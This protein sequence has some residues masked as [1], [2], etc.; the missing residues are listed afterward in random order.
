[1]ARLQKTSSNLRRLQACLFLGLVAGSARAQ[2]PTTTQPAA[3]SQNAQFV[4]GVAPGY[5][6]QTGPGLI[7]NL[8][9]GTAWCGGNVQ[10]YGGGALTLT[11][12][13]TNYVY[14]DSQNLCVPS[15]K[16][17]ALNP[18]DIPLAIVATSDT[19]ILGLSDVRT[20]FQPQGSGSPASATYIADFP[21]VVATDRLNNCLTAASA[22]TLVCD[23][24]AL[25]GTLTGTAFTIPAKTWLKTGLV[26]L[27]LSPGAGNF[28]IVMADT[29]RWSGFSSGFSSLHPGTVV[30]IQNSG[31]HG[32]RFN[33]TNTNPCTTGGVTQSPVIEGVEIRNANGTNTGIGIDWS[34]VQ[35]GTFFNMW[36]HQWGIA[37]LCNSTTFTASEN[38][39]YNFFTS[40]LSGSELGM[41]VQGTCNSNNWYNG[42]IIQSSTV[43]SKAVQLGSTSGTQP[44]ENSWFGMTLE[45]A[46]GNVNTGVNIDGL[47]GFRSF[48]GRF[49]GFLNGIATNGANCANISR[50]IFD[51]PW[52]SSNTT[53]VSN[54]CTQLDVRG[55]RTRGTVTLAA[56]VGS[57][58]FTPA[59]QAAPTCQ[60]TNTSNANAVKCLPAAGSLAVTG[61]G[62]DA[63]AYVCEGNPQ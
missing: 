47:L 24:T 31:G 16:T 38:G 36:V 59:Y 22:T 28:A 20:Q 14:L 2:A 4:N 9:P 32:I 1:M 41:V 13:A 30:A 52:M 23:A 10:T 53:N 27:N 61:T 62:T 17:G 60:C 54:T 43:G 50:V 12:S 11:A 44:D 5:R 48:G 35:H 39:F 46:G 6:P 25:H 19:A 55:V 40:D 51:N 15:A 63:I 58:T 26:T 29:A 49:E 57:A 7:L 21:G 34:G 37:S 18:Q 8:G 3:S 42:H 56:G 33:C 45:G